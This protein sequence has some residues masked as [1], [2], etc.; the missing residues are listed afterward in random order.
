MLGMQKKNSE[1][2]DCGAN[3]VKGYARYAE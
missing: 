2:E 3:I 1:C